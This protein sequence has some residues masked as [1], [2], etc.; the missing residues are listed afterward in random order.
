MNNV[1]AKFYPLT[2]EKLDEQNAILEKKRA[3]V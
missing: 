2:K 3:E 1:F